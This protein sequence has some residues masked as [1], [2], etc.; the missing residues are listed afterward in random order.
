[1][2]ENKA[3]KP[4]FFN[5]SLAALFAVGG[6]WVLTVF[7][8][9][10]QWSLNPQYAYG[11]LTI[12]LAMYLLWRETEQDASIQEKRERVPSWTLC[13]GALCLLSYLPLWFIQASSPDWR[14]LNWLIYIPVVLLTCIWFYNSGGM[15]GVRKLVFPLFFIGTSIPWLLSW[16]LKFATFLQTKVSLFVQE[17]LL[18][19]GKY[20]EIEGNLIRLTN[21]TVGVDEACSG[22]R[23]LQSSFVVSLFI[24]QY[25]R[26]GLLLRSLLVFAS[27]VFAFFLNLLRASFLAHLSA[28]RGTDMASKWHDPIGILESV[29][30]LVLLVLLVF[31]LIKFCKVPHSLVTD[32]SRFG[33]FNFLKRPFPKTLGYFAIA[34]FPLVLGITSFWFHHKQNSIPESPSI[35]VDFQANTRSYNKQRISDAIKTQLNFTKAISGSWVSDREQEFIGFYCRWEQGSGSPLALAVHT[36]EVCLQ[37]RGYRFLKRHEDISVTFPFSPIPVPF[38]AY[39]FSYQDQIVH[40]YRCYWPDRIMDGQFPGFP[41]QGYN[42]MGRLKAAMNGYRNPGA[43]MIAVGVFETPFINS[44]NIATEV[45]KNELK[46]RVIETN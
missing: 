21:C 41:R 32:D 44:F 15:K 28:S 17:T 11:W 3:T 9:Q 25:L 18:L 7:Q 31:F 8:L 13:L 5:E 33:S 20:A 36:P 35:K 42:T 37:L 29:G 43:N 19:A 24:G 2:I 46:Q 39:S 14:L 34:W 12:P 40:I 30:T 23:G 10:K 26:F 4:F 38:E 27:I 22:I 16:D 1:M 6:A 45:I